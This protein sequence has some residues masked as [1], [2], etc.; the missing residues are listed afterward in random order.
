MLTTDANVWTMSYYRHQ[1]L[2]AS[3]RVKKKDAMGRTGI[4]GECE[5]LS[6]V[7]RRAMPNVANTANPRCLH[8]ESI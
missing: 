7:V 3:K 2:T 4:N 1:G 8:L 6:L 5:N